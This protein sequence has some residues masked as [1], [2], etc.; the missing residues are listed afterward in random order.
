M[1]KKCD[2]FDF[3]CKITIP[4]CQNLSVSQKKCKKIKKNGSTC[5]LCYQNREVAVLLTLMYTDYRIFRTFLVE[6]Y[7]SL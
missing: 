1:E 7:N 5:I 2:F 3:G 4:N 6:S